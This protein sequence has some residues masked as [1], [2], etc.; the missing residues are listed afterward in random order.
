MTQTKTSIVHRN[1]DACERFLSK[2]RSLIIFMCGEPKESDQQESWSIEDRL[3]PFVPSEA[4]SKLFDGLLRMKTSVEESLLPECTGSNLKR[5]EYGISAVDQAFAQIATEVVFFVRNEA[6][7]EF[8][9]RIQVLSLNAPKT[10]SLY[11]RRLRFEL[12]TFQKVVAGPIY[13]DKAVRLFTA[14]DERIEVI[15]EKAEVEKAQ[16]AA[17]KVAA[18]LAPPRAKASRSRKHRDL[19]I[20]QQPKSEDKSKGKGS[21]DENRKRKQ[22]AAYV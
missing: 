12:D 11:G 16:L 13:V 20:R 10:F 22:E 4:F 8:D 3:Y 2:M 9:T 5:I 21:K 6:V 18:T 1:V 7:N 19:S 15:E 14:V 17:A